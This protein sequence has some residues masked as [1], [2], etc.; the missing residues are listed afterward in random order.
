M[1][2]LSFERMEKFGGN[3]I[4]GCLDAAVGGTSVIV[5]AAAIAAGLAAGPIGWI[6]LGLA[7]LATAGTLAEGDPCAH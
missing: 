2:E 5:N 6:G 4:W 1:K 7:V 3:G